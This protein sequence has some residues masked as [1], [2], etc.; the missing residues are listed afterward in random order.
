M[1]DYSFVLLSDGSSDRALIPIL[2]WLLREHFGTQHAFTG[3]WADLREL[4]HPP[5]TL[6]EKIERC[7]Q[8][9]EWDLLF[10]HRDAERQSTESRYTEIQN[11]LSSVT[12]HEKV[13][14]PPH[15]GVVPVRMQEAW[16]LFDE[17]AIRNAAENPN[18]KIELDLPHL[19]TVEAI[20]DPKATLY[21]ALRTASQLTGRR[22][23]KFEVRRSAS[24]VSDFIDDFSPLR[25]LPA[26]QRLETDIQNLHLAE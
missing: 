17:Q 24:R 18:G 12:R 19:A 26:F 8:L 20:A 13:V 11:A 10:V 25:V 14:V 6:S 16:L 5:Q 2:E 7:L 23:Q 9:Y 3:D 4:R 22:L 21:E 1:A 15:I